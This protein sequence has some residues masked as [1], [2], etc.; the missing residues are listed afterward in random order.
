MTN[1]DDE[2]VRLEQLRGLWGAR[3]SELRKAEHVADFHESVRK[4]Y[5]NLIDGKESHDA[6]RKLLDGLIL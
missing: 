4:L 5:P 3:P 1:T 6:F 2:A